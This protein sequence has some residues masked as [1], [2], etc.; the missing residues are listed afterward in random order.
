MRATAMKFWASKWAGAAVVAIAIAV[1]SPTLV[2]NTVGF[3]DEWLWDVVSPLR[4]PSAQVLHDVWFEPDAQLRRPYGLEYL[5]VRDMVVMADMAAWGDENDHGPHLTQLILFALTVYGLG[6]LLVRFGFAKHVA[7]L[8]ALAWAIHP[9]RVESVAWLSERKGILAGLFVVL[10]GHAWVRYRAGRSPWWLVAAALAAIAGCWSKA[11]AMFGPPAIILF[12]AILLPRARRFWIGGAVLAVATALAAAPVVLIARDAKVIDTTDTPDQ[13]RWTSFLGAQGH[14]WET[15]LLARGVSVDYPIQTDGPSGAELAIGA[16]ALLASIGLAYRW[17]RQPQPLALL[18]W[19]WLWYLPIGHLLVPVHILAADRFAFWWTLGPIVGAVLALDRAPR[20]R[21]F[22][23]LALIGGLAIATFRA[24]GQWASSVELF[25]RA[26]ES[27]PDDPLAWR[28]LGLA[29]SEALRPRLAMA[30]VERGL[31][32][33]PKHIKLLLAKATI[34]EGLHRHFAALATVRLAAATGAA[35]AKWKLATMLFADQRTTEALPWAREAFFKH[36]D[37]ADYARDYGVIALA[38][39]QPEIAE[40]AFRCLHHLEAR[41]HFN[42]GIALIELKR[43]READAMFAAAIA[44]APG[45]V[46]EV[47]AINRQRR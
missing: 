46:R 36:P 26:T 40:Q 6:G 31:V 5:P 2:F 41:D 37:I 32:E 47:D 23:A 21:P 17:R 34:Q 16:L 12:D 10:C 44:Q 7:W 9:M 25:S 29:Y 15:L 27:N 11:P 33:H 8:G 22:A 3:D 42:L 14:Y 19:T 28:H 4:H 43:P 1:Y 38:N 18:A 13:A 20:I 30:A 35:S 24:E 39:R 45:I